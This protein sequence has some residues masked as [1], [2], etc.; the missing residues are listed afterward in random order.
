MTTLTLL[1]ALT[2]TAGSVLLSSVL[3][4][5]YGI[6]DELLF[7]DRANT[8]RADP[9]R[10]QL[11]KHSLPEPARARISHRATENLIVVYLE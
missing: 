7:E 11:R 4:S 2:L 9:L 8:M 5:R 3:A 10:S 1:L 6:G